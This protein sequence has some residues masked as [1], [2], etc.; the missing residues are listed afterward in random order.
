MSYLSLDRPSFP[1]SGKCRRDY[2]TAASITC[3]IELTVGNPFSANSSTETMTRYAARAVAILYIC[4]TSYTSCCVSQREPQIESTITENA[5][6]PT[7]TGGN[8]ESAL[9]PGPNGTAETVSD[10]GERSNRESVS[11]DLSINAKASPRPDLSHQFQ[12]RTRVQITVRDITH[13]EKCCG[14]FIHPINE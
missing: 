10:A 13:N 2:A 6:I 7:S 1:G 14:E 12:F 5:S 9:V 3:P 8:G 4:V 11:P